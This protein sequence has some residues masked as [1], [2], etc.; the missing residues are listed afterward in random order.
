MSKQPLA[1]Q[2]TLPHPQSNRRRSRWSLFDRS[3][4]TAALLLGAATLG[5]A[6][7]AA[8]YSGNATPADGSATTAANPPE[9][10]SIQAESIELAQLSDKLKA[11]QGKVIILD[12]WATWC[13]HC[14]AELPNLVKLAEKHGDK[15]HAMTLNL[16]Y[17][18]GDPLDDEARSKIMR[19]LEK[20]G[21]RADN[22]ISTTGT[23]TVLE[24]LG[25]SAGLPTVVVFDATGKQVKVFDGMFS[26]EDDIAPLVEDLIAAAAD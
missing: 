18:S 19:V 17:E 7:G 14:I 21:I 13:G 22:Y 4:L 25:A 5:C 15:V 23:D 16:D 24:H 10:E 8:T 3:L 11:H 12:L 1:A 2:R 26:Y 6:D 20:R 9:V